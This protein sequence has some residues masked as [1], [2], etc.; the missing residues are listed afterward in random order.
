MIHP[1]AQRWSEPAGSASGTV[2]PGKWRSLQMLSFFVASG[3][4]WALDT[5][6]ISR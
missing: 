2:I 1:V 6:Y 3:F 5:R 4:Q